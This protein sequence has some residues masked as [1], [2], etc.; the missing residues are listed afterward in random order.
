MANLS[1]HIRA[2]TYNFRNIQF[3][4]IHTF[5]YQKTLLH[6]FFRLFLNLSKTFSVFL[7]HNQNK[8]EKIPRKIFEKFI[9]KIQIE[10]Q[11]RFMMLSLSWRSSNFRKQKLLKIVIC[12]LKIFIWTW[13]FFFQILQSGLFQSGRNIFIKMVQG[14]TINEKQ[15]K[16]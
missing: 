5:T 6:T 15:V 2:T 4:S 3:Q 16:E 14:G 12:Y 13:N 7:I 9:K 11:Q 8:T 1:N 10:I